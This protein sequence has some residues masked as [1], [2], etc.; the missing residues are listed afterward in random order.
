MA[1]S[2]AARS[3]R[4]WTSA[5]S[6]SG[7]SPP[8]SAIVTSRELRRDAPISRHEPPEDILGLPDQG[9]MQLLGDRALRGRAPHLARSG[10]VLLRARAPS[11]PT[12]RRSSSRPRSRSWRWMRRGTPS[13]AASCRP[14]SRPRQVARIEDGI[15]VNARRI[16]DEAAPTGGGDFVELIAKRLPLVTISD[17]I[18][19]PEADRERVVAAADTARHGVR[20]RGL[21]RAP[22]DRGARRGA[23]DADDVRHRARRAPRTAS[24][25][26]PDDRARPGRGR[27][28]A[29]DARRD[30]RV[31]RAAVGGRQRHDP[32]HHL[33]RDARVDAST[34]TSARC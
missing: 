1:A 27:R 5:H 8:R 29:P 17:M 3:P 19:V 31:L 23:V 2:E 26:R 10:D 25:R 30:R 15:R 11:S 24:R 28:R 14:R 33:A 13:C 32:P 12:R 4:T 34:P 18:G 16:V 9:R 21:R 22:A 20:P 6:I 7:P